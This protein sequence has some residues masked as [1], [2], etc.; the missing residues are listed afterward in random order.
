MNRDRIQRETFVKAPVERVWAV[1][2]E[3]KHVGVWFGQGAPAE[4]DLRPGGIMRL[5]H[6]EHGVYPT[7]IVAVD[8][9]RY[10]A[11]R[12]AGGYPGEV[13]DEANSTLVEFFLDAEEDGT[14]LRVTESGF[15]ALTI[16]AERERSAGYDSHDRGWREV[17]DNL[18]EYAER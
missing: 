2:T 4:V 8:P 5:D 14:R 10:L 13:A 18:K 7:L 3:P 12:W 6:G 17:V 1:I 16:P 9:P 15:A 11:Y